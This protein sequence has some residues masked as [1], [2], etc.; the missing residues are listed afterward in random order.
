MLSSSPL[1]CVTFDPDGHLLAAGCWDGN[2]TVWNWLQNKTLPVSY[3]EQR[4]LLSQSCRGYVQHIDCFSC[5]LPQSLS[6]HQ[7]SVRSLCFSSSS[8]S[9]LC[10]GSVSG[11]VRVW[12]VPTSTCVGCFQAHCGAV[13]SLSFLDGGAMLLSAGSDHMVRL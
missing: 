5:L 1:N 10:S 4:W 2:V 3:S 6:G 13:Q 11:E 9:M 7:R 8:S 12:S